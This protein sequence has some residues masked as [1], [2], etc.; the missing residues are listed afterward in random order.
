[1]PFTLLHHSTCASVGPEH[2]LLTDAVAPS[3]KF[4]GHPLSLLQS[5]CTS[6]LCKPGMC[7]VEQLLASHGLLLA[8][9]QALAQLR[10]G[11]NTSFIQLGYNC[12]KTPRGS[13]TVEPMIL[14]GKPGFRDHY[15]NK[16]NKGPL[17]RGYS[18]ARSITMCWKVG[19]NNMGWGEAGTGLAGRTT[20]HLMAHW[21]G[22]P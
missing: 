8:V 1:M 4:P 18:P 11:Q 10:I 22:L 12:Y 13:S 7:A 6:K 17:T 2:C 5:W 16:P 19:V 20:C 15:T 14:Y 3:L 21:A 9:M